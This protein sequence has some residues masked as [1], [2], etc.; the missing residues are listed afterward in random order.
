MTPH[1]PYEEFA[2]QFPDLRH[3]VFNPA[4]NSPPGLRL[5]CQT[6]QTGAVLELSKQC[7]LSAKLKTDSPFGSLILEEVIIQGNSQQKS[8]EHVLNW[9][10][11][12]DGELK[13][14]EA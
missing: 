10:M 4:T 11:Q 12:V 2:V 8:A 9:R 3:V 7:P 1:K 6:Q 14:T 13:T 5:C